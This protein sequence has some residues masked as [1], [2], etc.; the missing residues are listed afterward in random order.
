MRLRGH[1]VLLLACWGS[2][3]FV[4]HAQWDAAPASEV[5]A[6]LDR[7]TTHYAGLKDF[8]LEYDMIFFHNST[9]KQP[10]ERYR[11]RIDR[12]GERY[13]ADQMGILTIQ[14]A[15]VRVCVD[16]ANRTVLLAP[17]GVV[18]D[19]TA[20]WETQ[21][22]PSARY[23]GKQHTDAG[24]R[25]RVMLPISSGFEAAE[26]LFDQAGWLREVA[27]F[28]NAPPQGQDLFSPAFNNPK[29][30]LSFERPKTL[31]DDVPSSSLDPASIVQLKPDGAVL[32]PRWSS[33][34]LIDTRY[35][36]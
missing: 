4:S 22:L 7:N 6:A 12:K 33:Y 31:P 36:R 30:V 2:W 13:C 18:M 10:R 1:I 26:I 25:Y 32:K 3:P 8:R 5:L 24:T 17:S 27:M 35:H 11:A 15:N 21:V 28:Y 9:D 34:E 19:H 16:T 23:I 20:S 14:D 29:V